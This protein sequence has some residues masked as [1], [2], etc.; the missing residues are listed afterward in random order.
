MVNIRG[1]TYFTLRVFTT[2]K[3]LFC[4]LINNAYHIRRR[5]ILL[6][7][8]IQT[9]SFANGKSLAE[10]YTNNLQTANKQLTETFI[11]NSSSTIWNDVVNKMIKLLLQMVNIRKVK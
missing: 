5:F 3:Q 1:N 4:N 9:T 7:T 10:I 2:F 8:N 11:I 6:L